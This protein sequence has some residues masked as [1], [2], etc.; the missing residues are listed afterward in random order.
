MIRNYRQHTFLPLPTHFPTFLP[1]FSPLSFFSSAQKLISDSSLPEHIDHRL[2]CS[3]SYLDTPIHAF[4]C[5]AHIH[6]VSLITGEPA[7]RR[8]GVPFEGL[9]EQGCEGERKAQSTTSGLKPRAY[10]FSKA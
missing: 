10:A 2:N 5:L 6:T 1:S 7:S 3:A 4:T 9:Q 8:H